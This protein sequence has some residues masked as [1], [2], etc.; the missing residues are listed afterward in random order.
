M[1]FQDRGSEDGAPLPTQKHSTCWLGGRGGEGTVTLLADSGV[2]GLRTLSELRTDNVNGG[3]WLANI[4]GTQIGETWVG[5]TKTLDPT[6][7]AKVVIADARF[8]RV[9]GSVISM[10]WPEKVEEEEGMMGLLV[11]RTG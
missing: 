9:C 6:L 7:R 10:V 1:E 4:C 2:K 5:H 11:K 3:S 8:D